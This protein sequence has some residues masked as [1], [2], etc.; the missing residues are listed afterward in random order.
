MPGPSGHPQR[1]KLNNPRLLPRMLLLG[2]KLRVCLPRI[3]FQAPSSGREQFPRTRTLCCAPT[4]RHSGS[5]QRSK[6]TQCVAQLA[7]DQARGRGR[8]T[9]HCGRRRIRG[10]LTIDH[11]APRPATR[12]TRSRRVGYLICSSGTKWYVD[13]HRSAGRPRTEQVP[14]VT[15]DIDEYGHLSVRILPCLG[16]E[17]DPQLAHTLVSSREILDA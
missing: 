13:D 2:S 17:V 12:R 4:P 15:G 8:P 10:S 5:R 3:R 9:R 11:A 14:A 1:P 7:V 16:S 6:V